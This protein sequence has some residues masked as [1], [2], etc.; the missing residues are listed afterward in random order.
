MEELKRSMKLLNYYNQYSTY[1]SSM[2]G[3]EHINEKYVVFENLRFLGIDD[4]NCLRFELNNGCQI[5]RSIDDTHLS[6]EAVTDIEYSKDEIKKIVF[7]EITNK[8]DTNIM[9]NTK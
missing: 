9:N 4:V 1:L 2:D 5:R 6:Y 8:D 3:K 7:K